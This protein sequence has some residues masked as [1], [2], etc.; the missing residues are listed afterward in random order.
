MAG[1]RLSGLASIVVDLGRHEID[2][3]VIRDAG[4]GSSSPQAA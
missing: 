4:L 2:V 3:L 1:N